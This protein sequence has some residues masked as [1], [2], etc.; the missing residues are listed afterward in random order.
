MSRRSTPER[1]EAARHAAAR[2]RLIGEARMSE[3][4]A[5]EWSPGVS[6]RRPR[7]VENATE[8]PAGT[9]ALGTATACT[10]R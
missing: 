8:C 10:G 2:N 1:L 9:E 4:R 6:Y 3:E 5:D 7:K